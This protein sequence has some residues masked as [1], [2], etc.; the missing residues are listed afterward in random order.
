MLTPHVPPFM[1]CDATYPYSGLI[2]HDYLTNKHHG[3][4][5]IRGSVTHN[6]T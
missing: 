2:Q 6:D 5:K 4:K 3:F 1:E